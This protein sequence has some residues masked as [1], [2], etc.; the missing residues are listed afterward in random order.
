[1][2]LR[3]VLV[4]VVHPAKVALSTQVPGATG[5]AI[6][7]VLAA[8]DWRQSESGTVAGQGGN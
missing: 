6:C 4:F 5:D 2:G 8:V 7:R 3:V 1:M